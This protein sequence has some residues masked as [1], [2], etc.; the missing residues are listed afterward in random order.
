MKKYPTTR[1][2]LI[3]FIVI[4]GVYLALNHREHLAPY[5]SF[6]FLL[7]CLFMHIFMHGRHGT[8]NSHH[9]R[10]DSGNRGR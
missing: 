2:T 5:A 10:D 7:G 9:G 6:F 8:H 4:V 3:F 1:I